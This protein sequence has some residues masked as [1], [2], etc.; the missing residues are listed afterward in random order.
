MSRGEFFRVSDMEESEVISYLIKRK[1]DSSM[2]SSVF[3]LVGGRNIDLFKVS[4]DIIKGI[5]FESI[6]SISS[7]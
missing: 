5:S 1:V 2:H 7:S 6:L 3:S 4:N